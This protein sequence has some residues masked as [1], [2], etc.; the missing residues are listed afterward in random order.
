MLATLTRSV[1]GLSA[2]R[3]R[4]LALSTIAQQVDAATAA[5]LQRDAVHVTTSADGAM[6]KSFYPQ[7]FNGDGAASWYDMRSGSYVKLSKEDLE[8]YLPEGVAGETAQE[9]AFTKQNAW[10][11]R[12]TTKVL[13]RLVEEVEGRLKKPFS[14]ASN[15][16]VQGLHSVIELP[17]LT[18]RPEWEAAQLEISCYGQTV[19]SPNDELNKSVFPAPVSSSGEAMIHGKGPKSLLERLVKK[20]GQRDGGVPNKIML[21]GKSLTLYCTTL[22]TNSLSLSQKALVVQASPWPS[23]RLYFM[24]E[25]VVGSQ[26]L[27]RTLGTTYRVAHT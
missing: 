9:F 3:S 26:C 14:H 16:Q 7:H 18:D 23:H 6:L 25:S 1:R 4:T 10:M 27:S 21:T 5:E 12:D 20:I 13:C 22:C 8:K 11:V 15:S 17:R 19:I 24:R 2:L